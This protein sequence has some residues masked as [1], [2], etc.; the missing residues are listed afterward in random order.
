MRL[1][2]DLLLWV[3]PTVEGSQTCAGTQPGKRMVEVSSRKL[4]DASLFEVYS[5][6]GTIIC[7]TVL[8]CSFSE[9]DSRGFGVQ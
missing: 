2:R 4:D 7:F 5:K 8:Y 1:C 9:C 3:Q 6:E